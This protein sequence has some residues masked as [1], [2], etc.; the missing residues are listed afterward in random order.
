MRVDLRR[1]YHVHRVHE[2]ERRKTPCKAVRKPS[3]KPVVSRHGRD[4]T[5]DLV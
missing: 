1:L 4:R 5:R 2:V 3:L